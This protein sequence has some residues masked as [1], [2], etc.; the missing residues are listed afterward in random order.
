MTETIEMKTVQ[1]SSLKSSSVL[2]N[3]MKHIRK[4]M[5]AISVCEGSQPIRFHGVVLSSTREQLY[6]TELSRGHLI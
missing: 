3:T 1:F 4:T 2:R 5:T 6:F